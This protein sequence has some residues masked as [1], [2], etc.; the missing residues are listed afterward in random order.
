MKLNLFKKFIIY[1][2]LFSPLSIG[3]I[4]CSSDNKLN[5][6]IEEERVINSIPSI[7]AVAAL[8]QLSPSGEIRK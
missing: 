6:K 7:N 1:L 3:L 4:S 5:S 2:F 8:G